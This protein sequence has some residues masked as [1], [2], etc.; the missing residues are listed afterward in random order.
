MENSS[1]KQLQGLTEIEVRERNLR[2]LLILIGMLVLV[3]LVPENVSFS[4]LLPF[5]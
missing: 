4:L 5:H 1:D 3:L 2:G